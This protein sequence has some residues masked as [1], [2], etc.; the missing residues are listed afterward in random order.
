V[1]V[2]PAQTNLTIVGLTPLDVTNTATDSDIHVVSLTYALLS[3]PTNAVISTNGIITWTPVVAQVPST[4]VF[5]TVA[6]AYDPQ[7]ANATS[8]SATNS[9]TVVVQAVH[10]PPVLPAQNNLAINELTPLTVT[11]TA[12]QSSIPPL[13][14][15]YTLVNPP[16]GAAID[17]NG[18]I[19]WT[20]TQA[21]APSTNVITTVVSDNG[22]PSLSATNSFTVVVNDLNNVPVLPA[23]TNRTIVGQTPLDVTNTATDSDIHVVSLT[24][25]LI[26]AP[27][28]AAI[29]A[30]GIITWTPLL[31]QVPS[32]NVFTTVV[33]AYDPQAANSTN[34]SAINSFTVVVQAPA[35]PP[36]L[37]SIELT[38]EIAT[39]TWSSAAD[40]TYRLQFKNALTDANWNDILP[41]VVA[42]G[43]TAS[44]TNAVNGATQR[45]YRVLLLP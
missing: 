40:S 22:T 12:S 19:T 15:A 8:L 41:D 3:A 34:L 20:P 5:T 26:S 10:N 27:T 9:F 18:I 44:M 6:T 16:G 24:Y 30:N 11:N 35:P 7:A 2:L 25:A 45:F 32:T 23:Q 36:V 39:V 21:E 14:L 17:A 43:S 33:T 29:S 13:T 28:N 1:P 38:N 37:Q 4:N 42:A 31:S